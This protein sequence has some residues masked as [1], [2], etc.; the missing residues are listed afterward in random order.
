MNDR[1]A[2][3]QAEKTLQDLFQQK[4]SLSMMQER[5]HRQEKMPEIL[6]I[7]VREVREFLKADRVTIY[8]CNQEKSGFVV[9]VS[10]GTT[11]KESMLGLQVDERLIPAAEVQEYREGKIKAI[12]DI[13][14][15]GLQESQVQLL[16]A[17]QVVAKVGV[18]LRVGDSLWGLLM[19]HQCNGPRKWQPLE[20]DALEQLATQVAIAIQQLELYQQVQN[21]NSVLE[22]QVRERTAQ[23]EQ[24]LNFEA[25]LKR[26]TDKVR[27]SL[28]ETQIWQAAVREVTEVLG[29]RGCNAALYDQEKGTSIISAAYSKGPMI[30]QE[31]VG[32]VAALKKFPEIYQQQ[33]L[34]G[35]YFQFCSLLPNPDRG[36]VAMLACPIFDNQGVLGDLWLINHADYVFSELQIR[37]V[38][39]VANQCAIALRQAR[40]YQAAQT[41]VEELQKLS[42]LKD[43]FVST[44]QHELRTPMTNMTMAIKM[45][46]I[47]LRQAGVL[48]APG[49]EAPEGKPSKVDHY[50]K[51]IQDECKREISLINDLLDLQ[52]LE[53]QSQPIASEAIEFQS[54]LR[55]LVKPFIDRASSRQQVLEVDLDDQLPPVISDPAILEGVIRE[56]LNNACKYT[57]PGER[58]LRSAR[59]HQD[60]IILRVTNYGVVIPAN[61][62][63]RIFDKF[64]RVPSTD[65]W[66]Q[67]GT[68][69]GLALVQKRVGRLGG[70]IEVESGEGKTCFTIELPIKI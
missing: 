55:T 16:S 44:V 46:T 62:L 32:R 65:P 13:Y 35:Q 21:L 24:A 45:L 30:N 53:N 68:G 41:Q 39:Q 38:Q 1:K 70:T 4:M 51:I 9:I 29:I 15:A 61:E 54:W 5:I 50:W 31:R 69:L 14:R 20:M 37:L 26:I 47:G 33:L 3:K 52:Q 34:Q 63:P 40:L 25:M 60:K 7:T 43:E 59:S 2:R 17:S 19:V 18:P 58:I 28:D 8:R 27:D 56:L 42:R 6:S 67:G 11:A 23:L 22:N 48:P 12:A 66:K 10:A 57:P 64:Y 49:T 36:R